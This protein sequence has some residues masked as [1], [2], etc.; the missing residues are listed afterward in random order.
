MSLQWWDGEV[1]YIAGGPCGVPFVRKVLDSKLRNTLHMYTHSISCAF[2]YDY[3]NA[4]LKTRFKFSMV[5]STPLTICNDRIG[6]SHVNHK[7]FWLCTTLTRIWNR[8]HPPCM[9]LIRWR[10]LLINKACSIVTHVCDF[11]S[12]TCSV[13]RYS[14]WGEVRVGIGM[15]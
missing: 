9:T 6:W 10:V 15:R 7:G 2:T 8:F 11:Y 3:K 4:L 12:K 13:P 1:I 5:I 14:L